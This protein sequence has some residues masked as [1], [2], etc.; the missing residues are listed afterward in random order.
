[1]DTSSLAGCSILLYEDEPLIRM[2]IE[3]AFSRAGAIV[4]STSSEQEAL[5]VMAERSVSAAILDRG[6]PELRARLRAQN[7]PFLIYS[8]F[9]KLDDEHG[10]AVHISKPASANMLVTT[11]VGLLQDRFTL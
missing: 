3:D 11:V 1:M 10:D 2:D 6:T 7:I 4:V 5:A 8:G 9:A